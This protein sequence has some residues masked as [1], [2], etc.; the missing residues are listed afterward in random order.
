M[1][2][3]RGTKESDTGAGSPTRSRLVR[4]GTHP[5][6]VRNGN[7]NSG[8]RRQS[9]AVPDR[10]AA[11]DNVPEVPPGAA[12]SSARDKGDDDVGGVAVEVLASAV[13]DRCG[14]RV[15]MSGSELDV[16]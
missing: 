9:R 3:A 4:R 6:G 7:G 14:A 13:V 10:V 5:V 1:I 8:L 16:T 11:E 2:H 12:T 15:G